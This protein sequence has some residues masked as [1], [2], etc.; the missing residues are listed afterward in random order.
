VAGTLASAAVANAPTGP[1][2]V[3]SCGG[4][5]AASLAIAP[6]VRGARTGATA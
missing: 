5:L 4:L 3:L 2:I 1:F 6:R